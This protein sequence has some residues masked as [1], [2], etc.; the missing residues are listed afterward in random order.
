MYKPL[1]MLGL[2]LVITSLVCG[3]LFADGGG[4]LA[5]LE[6]TWHAFWLSCVWLAF[7]MLMAWHNGRYGGGPRSEDASV[8]EYNTNG[9]PML[10]STDV[11]GNAYG[12]DSSSHR[13]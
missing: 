6:A 10:G 11:E 8:G 1:I 7:C 3:V 4:V 2:L 9:M 13:E 5:F 12:S